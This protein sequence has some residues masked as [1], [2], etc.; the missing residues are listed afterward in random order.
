MI[1]VAMVEANIN[2]QKKEGK[3]ISYMQKKDLKISNSSNNLINSNRNTIK[4]KKITMIINMM[5]IIIE[6][7]IEKKINSIFDPCLIVFSF[8]IFVV[9]KKMHIFFLFCKN[10]LAL[11]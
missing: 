10:K 4:R 7:S 5:M 8:K 3:G 2:N 1:I 6:V 9:V 11:S